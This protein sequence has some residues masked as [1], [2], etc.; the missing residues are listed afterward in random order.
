MDPA[1]RNFPVPIGKFGTPP[2]IAAAVCFLLSPEASFCCGSVLFVD[3]GT[4]TMLR[5]DSY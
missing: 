5:P 4:D 1:I 2:Q 3:G